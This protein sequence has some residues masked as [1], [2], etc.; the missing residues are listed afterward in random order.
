MDQALGVLPSDYWRWWLLSHAPES[1]DSEF[2]WENF[3]ASVNK[4]LA[5]VLGNFVSR[6]TKFC[7]ARFGETLPSGGAPG[8][9][10][11][12]Q[13]GKEYGQNFDFERVLLNSQIDNSGHPIAHL[14]RL[15]LSDGRVLY[16]GVQRESL[17]GNAR[18]IYIEHSLL[19]ITSSATL[20]NVSTNQQVYYQDDSNDPFSGVLLEGRYKLR[21]VDSN[22]T[23]YLGNSNAGYVLDKME[24]IEAHFEYTYQD[25]SGRLDRNRKVFEINFEVK[26][27]N[28]S[29]VCYL[30]DPCSYSFEKIESPYEDVNLATESFSVIENDL[31]KVLFIY[32][33]INEEGVYDSRS[34]YLT[35]RELDI[36]GFEFSESYA[37]VALDYY[38]ARPD[39]MKRVEVNIFTGQPIYLNV[40]DLEGASEDGYFIHAFDVVKTDREVL[41]Y[42]TMGANTNKQPIDEGD[43]RWYSTYKVDEFG[44]VIGQ[45]GI[46]FFLT[47][48]GAAYPIEESLSTVPRS[49]LLGQD[50]NFFTGFFAS[51][52][53]VENRL[54]IYRLTRALSGTFNQ[55]MAASLFGAMKGTSGEDYQLVSLRSVARSRAELTRSN[56]DLYGISRSYNMRNSEALLKF[57]EEHQVSYFSSGPSFIKADYDIENDT[58]ILAVLSYDKK[59]PLILEHRPTGGLHEATV[60]FHFDSFEHIKGGHSTVINSISACRAT[61][62]FLYSVATCNSS[63]NNCELAIS[64]P[65]LILQGNGG[66]YIESGLS[67]IEG[68]ARYGN[69]LNIYISRFQ[70]MTMPMLN[71]YNSTYNGT[72]SGYI[73]RDSGYLYL[74]LGDRLSKR[75]VVL[76]S[77]AH[78]IRPFSRPLNELYLP[79]YGDFTQVPFA[80]FSNV[81]FQDSIVR[82]PNG[83]EVS[84][85]FVS[86]FINWNVPGFNNLAY[87]LDEGYRFSARLRVSASSLEDDF[88]ITLHGAKGVTEGATVRLRFSGQSLSLYRHQAGSYQLVDTVNVDISSIRDCHVLMKRSGVSTCQVMVIIKRANYLQYFDDFTQ[89]VPDYRNS[90]VVRISADIPIVSGFNGTLASLA[91][92]MSFSFDNQSETIKEESADLYQFGWGSLTNSDGFYV[93]NEIGE[94]GQTNLTNNRA[95]IRRIND[96]ISF[97]DGVDIVQNFPIVLSGD[98]ESFRYRWPSG[99]VFR[100]DGESIFAGDRWDLQR[101]SFQLAS[102]SP[103]NIHTIW[104][105]DNDGEGGIIWADSSDSGLDRFVV[106]TFVAERC[107]VSSIEVVGRDNNFEDW[108]IIGKLS[109]D[110]YSVDVEEYSYRGNVVILKIPSANFLKNFEDGTLYYREEGAPSLVILDMEGDEI[111]AKRRAGFSY[112]GGDG[113]VYS[114]R[115]SLILEEPLRY[116]YVGFRLPNEETFEGFFKVGAFA[117][118]KYK[119][120][121]VERGVESG[122][123]VTYSTDGDVLYAFDNQSFTAFDRRVDKA[124][125]LTYSIFD[126]LSY[127]RVKS[128]IVESTFSREPV[129]IID[130]YEVDGKDLSLCLPDGNANFSVLRDEDGE[131]Y[132]SITLAFKSVR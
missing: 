19:G 126:S 81:E 51:S 48:Q 74:T 65:S 70:N 17:P 101:D 90:E 56:F 83:V 117:L 47:V 67:D 129:W 44:T 106:D 42:V 86:P 49:W 20:H 26:R 114:D 121:P 62:G 71:M 29:F 34:K 40:T 80:R 27:Y 1:G 66:A 50:P 107:N 127:A 110:K 89:D 43:Y 11:F 52:P 22:A 84:S 57:F 45:E 69:D 105:S 24:D 35:V 53:F 3:Q 59:L 102:L 128:A 130:R 8:F 28:G 68:Y 119:T 88:T 38:L 39:V 97:R 108:E 16:Y 30:Y 96:A 9:T 112:T 75:P 87:I 2:T 41:A 12:D 10:I 36:E 99:Y 23:V 131:V 98:K 78:D 116:R 104:H 94:A 5:D 111:Y 60:P 125:D 6:I 13:D 122:S 103:K 91:S 93:Y 109:F 18:E 7:R 76:V 79:E 46:F 64:D 37:E 31:G 15:S 115:A 21:L 132:Y 77:G 73:S 92:G 118:G 55:I 85:S 63:R 100:F 124:Y 123:G 113:S 14:R 58:T 95:L 25:V 61:D 72:S 32:S 82:I 120:L 33:K 4:D 54:E